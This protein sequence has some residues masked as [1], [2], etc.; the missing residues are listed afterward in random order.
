MSALLAAHDLSIGYGGR[1]LLS[2]INL[3]I[4]PG[5]WWGV[6][7]PNG[8]GKTTLMKTLLGIVPA[9]AGRIERRAGL[10]FGYVPQRGVIDDIFPLPALDVVVMGRYPRIG[11]GRP[12]TRADR[13]LALS[14]MERVSI[15][16]LARKSFRSLSGGQ[17]QRTLI[18]R[19]LVPEPDVLVLDEPTDGMDLA[20][21]TGIMELITDLQRGSG[22]TLLMISHSLNLVANH[23][24][25][26]MLIHG[27]EGVFRTGMTDELLNGKTLEE[28]YHVSVDVHSFAGRRFVV[29]HGSP[30]TGRV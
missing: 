4:E 18:A 29:A 15:A 10:S 14:Y 19:G 5:D 21:E 25:Q 28:V 1:A 12:V 7:G 6:V 22:R 20:G 17:K 8:A 24:K 9:L 27:D 3:S 23:A 2:G 11:P 30:D 26:L 13:E 16:H